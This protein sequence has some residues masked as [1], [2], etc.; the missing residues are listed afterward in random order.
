M[1][2]RYNS[3]MIK[4]L[5]SDLNTAMKRR[6]K[7]TVN[8]LRMVLSDL[9]NRKIAAGR[10]LEEEQI[11]AALRTAVKQ[12]REAAE[13]FAEGGRQDR[14]E[15]E[16]AEIEVIKAYLPKLLEGDELSAA[17]DEVIANTGASLPSDTGKVMGQLMSR[18][19][20]R[21]DGKAAN[22]LVRQRLVG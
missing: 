4:R 21:V 14:S 5:R 8:V 7:T 22:A 11:I 12:R 1:S 20:G 17:V 15:A 9:H 2:L 13:L 3:V 18:Y 6:E 19:Q 16:L 10:D